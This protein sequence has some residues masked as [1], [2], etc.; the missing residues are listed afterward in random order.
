M[1]YAEN[2]QGAVSYAGQRKVLSSESRPY[3]ARASMP[4]GRVIAQYCRNRHDTQNGEIMHK[5]KGFSL[6]EL[7]IVGRDHFDHRRDR[8]SKLTAGTHCG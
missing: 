6:I 4:D 3:R 2:G 8:Y 1:A 5:Q 7:L